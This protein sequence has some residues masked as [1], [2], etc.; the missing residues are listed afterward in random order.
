MTC[1][2]DRTI[3]VPSGLYEPGDIVML[4]SLG[5]DMTVVG[6][7]PECGE[8][9]CAWFMFHDE[10]ECEYFRETFPAAALELAS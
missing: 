5:P 10:G 2:V 1:T 8:V 7:C 4:A 9:E 3:P 6:V